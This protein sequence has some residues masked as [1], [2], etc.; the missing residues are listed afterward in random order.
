[1]RYW[2]LKSEPS[3][4]SWDQLV[5]DRRTNWSGVRNF[6]AANNL[7]AMKKGDRAFFY[8]S[9]EG[10]AVV[11]AVEIVKEAYPDPSDKSGRFVMVDVAPLTPAKQPVTLAEIKQTP[12]LKDLA[13]VKQS[14]LSVSPVSAEEWRVI[15]KMAGIKA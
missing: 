14:R 8:H 4:Y 9:N 1:M 10:L 13:L 12:A 3:A 15:A 11:G 6:Q 7:K 5:K 2:L